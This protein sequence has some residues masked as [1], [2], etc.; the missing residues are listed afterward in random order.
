M[1][2]LVLG[3]LTLWTIGVFRLLCF[4]T[5]LG[6]RT[7]LTFAALGA[8]LGTV[9]NPVAEKFFNS[10]RYEGNPFYVLL[11]V[12]SQHLLMAGP[13][14]LLLARPAWRYG[15][16]LCDGFLAAFAVGAGYEFLGLLM[17]LA[18]SQNLAAGLSIVPPGV[19]SANGVTIAGYAY[20]SGFTCL[21]GAAAF[22][23][24]RNRV[25]AWAAT[26]LALIGC[27]LD[28]FA[29]L[30]A[31]PVAENIRTFTLHGSLLAWATILLLIACVVW[32]V[33]WTRAQGAVQEALAEFQTVV[34]AMI[35]LKWNQAARAG[36]QH[37]LLRQS[38]ILA[39][40]ERRDPANVLVQRIAASVSN[41]RAVLDKSAPPSQS[42]LAG[43]LRER[44]PQLLAVLGFFG[45]GVFLQMP[46]LTGLSNWL[47]TSL[48]LAVR[49]APFQ[50][51]LLA[52]ILVVLIVWQYLQAPARPFSS[53]RT[54]EVAQFSAERRILQLGLGV[55]L[56][57]LLYPHPAELT[58]FQSTLS[59]AAGL[60][61]PGWSEE[62]AI[63]L[64]LLLAWAAG[65]LTAKRAELWRKAV[66]GGRLRTLAHNLVSFCS[67]AAVAWL[68][69]SFFT[70][71]Q[72]YAHARWGADFFNRFSTNGN[73]ILEMALG[74]STAVFSFAVAWL[75]RWLSRRLEKD[76]QDSDPPRPA[77]QRV[78]VAG[79]GS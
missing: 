42:G 24:L 76:L 66:G 33:R 14:L 15:S 79:S 6:P 32:E 71:A 72:V 16:S 67:L 13:V 54:D 27:A 61:A 19:V 29:T 41:S 9:A 64:V 57:A 28:H 2:L 59:V 3:V 51:T 4:R 30:S 58:A 63:T 38:E 70:Q 49:F 1:P 65:G 22:R 21:V 23:W 7:L 55:V 8:L 40:E 5:T 35:G 25:L 12:A 74:V 36:T 44:W 69:L 43:W 50:L 75:L 31:A 17:A 53:A 62:Q 45:F 26:A 34:A 46:D 11:I 18:P 77:P 60:Q 78:A 37:H 48:P 39:A 68:A 73:S 10:Y 56:I 47:W 20:W 52:T